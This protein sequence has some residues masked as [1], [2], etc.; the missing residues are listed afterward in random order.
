MTIR[1]RRMVRTG[2]GLLVGA[3]DAAVARR[4]SALALVIRIG[5]AGLAFVAQVV[6]ARLMAQ[7]EYG[8]FA[9]T[10]VWFTILT[11]IG[12]LGFGDSPIRYIP[13][14]RERGDADQL[15]G[16]IRFA[17]FVTVAAS[18]AMA[19]FIIFALPLAGGWLESVYI[20]PAVLM[21][22]SLPFACLQSTLEG[23]GR[24]YGWTIPSLLPVYILRH[25]LLLIFMAGAVTFG[26]DASA[27]NGF[28]CLAATLL[29]TTLYQAGTILVRLRRAIPP[30]PAAYRPR[31]WLRGAS[32]FAVL[33]GSSYLS[34][35][36]DVLVL[37]L[38]VSPAEI[39]IYFAA[40]RIIQVV[41]L[42]PFAAMVGA[43]HLF[44]ATHTRGDHDELKRLVQ[45]VSMTTFAVAGLAVAVILI[46]GEWMLALFGAG[47]AA[48]YLPLTILAVGVLARIAA[49]PGED[50]LNMTGH[51]SVSAGTYLAIMAVGVPLSIALIVPF[52]VAGAALATSL[53]LITRAAWLWWD[54][55]RRFGIDASIFA[56]AWSWTRRSRG[57]ELAVAAE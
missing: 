38:F 4:A 7:F 37:S 12:T 46:V 33:H 11:A 56:A 57:A 47:F 16:F 2:Y 3:N 24:T 10:W 41:N 29:L 40:T 22:V 55:R 50:V 26:A 52:G 30:G 9:Y 25:G 6:L 18:A 5:N 45:H 51:G 28:L 27:V 54:V 36:T 34:S 31:E 21:A 19:A 23:I 20:L 39:A 13:L 35:F 53:A 49:G 15:R 14:L 1:L 48:G 44:A 42:V 17:L 8:I 32:P 43:A